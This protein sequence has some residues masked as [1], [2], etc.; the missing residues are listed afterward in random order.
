MAYFFSY[1]SWKRAFSQHR[2]EVLLCCGIVAFAIG[3]I[4]CVVAMH[5]WYQAGIKI[6]VEAQEQD[7]IV[8]STSAAEMQNEQT[9]IPRV[10]DGI[11][12][13]K[14]LAATMPVC[15]MIENAAF[16]GVRPQTSL[17]KASIVYEVIVEGGI[18]RFMAVY[19]TG[20]ESYTIGP[21]R[22]ARDTYI[23]FASEYECPY[24]HAGGSP[25]ALQALREHRMW[26]LDGL[27]YSQYFWRDAT[28]FAPHNFF[29][30]LENLQSAAT[31]KHWAILDPEKFQ[32]WKFIDAL[33]AEQ[34]PDPATEE[35]VTTIFVG[36]GGSYDVEYF[37]NAEKNA[38]ER[39]NGG[40]DHTDRLNNQIL[41]ATN[42]V[43]Q[44]VDDGT[45]IE[46]KGRINWPVRGEGR[47]EIFH[48]GQIYKGRWKKENRDS[49]TEYVDERGAPIPLTRGTTWVEVVPPHIAVTYQ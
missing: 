22:S 40:V 11:Y 42:I 8:R 27:I 3:W 4:F 15:V 38:Y 41:T 39:K 23:E 1:R 10:L 36:F 33:P 14:T 25:T 24:A 28:K 21:V 2:H 6:S 31:D 16:G 7:M 26:D 32:P 17:S 20:G 46:G 13:E 37:Y 43:L 19:P 44:F 12:V 35:G 45:A 30:S 47:V 5:R 48:D 18:T 29:T 9:I 34:R 49:R